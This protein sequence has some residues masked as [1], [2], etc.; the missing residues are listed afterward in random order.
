MKTLIL[1][2]KDVRALLTLDLAVPAVEAAFRAHGLGRAQMPPKVYLSLE[3]VGGDFRAMPS[4]LDG[5]AGVKWVNSHPHNP[6]RHN[7]PTV[8]GVYILSDPET[9]LPLAVMDATWLTAARTGAAA[10]VASRYLARKDVKTLG[11]LGCGVQARPLVAAHRVVYGDS[12]RV[13]AFDR[14]EEAARK[15][16]EECGAEVSTLELVSGCDI[17]CTSTPGHGVALHRAHVARGAHINAMGADAPGKQEIEG[18]ILNHARVVIDDWHQATH[19]GE[20]NVPIHDGEYAESSIY[21]TL[22]EIVA[23]K[24][25]GRDGDEIS[26]FDST[27]LAIQD[28]AVARIVHDAA[29][30]RGIGVEVDLVG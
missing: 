6:A 30:S 15:F 3:S 12:L 21:G 24:K 18:S 26:V 16:A 14:S 9:A 11:L 25:H 8:M 10:A 13:L 27:G 5:A 22:G 7:L 1:S 17:V 23:G 2:Q 19:S 29:R 4:F 20:V 28:V